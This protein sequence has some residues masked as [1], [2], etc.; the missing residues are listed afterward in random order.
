MDDE[1]HKLIKRLEQ[2]FKDAVGVLHANAGSYT[3]AQWNGKYERI[4]AIAEQL[5]SLKDE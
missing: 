5:A 1:R 2:V 3:E 4:T